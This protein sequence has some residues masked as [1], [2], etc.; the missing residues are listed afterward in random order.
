M[1]LLLVCVV[2]RIMRVS[3]GTR[4]CRTVLGAS[5]AACLNRHMHRRVKQ[6]VSIVFTA[7]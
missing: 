6:G 2:I 1:F 3:T 5:L 7:L 4:V